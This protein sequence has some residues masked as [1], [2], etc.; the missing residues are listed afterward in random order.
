LGRYDLPTLP[1]DGHEPS[2][3]CACRVFEPIE[4]DGVTVGVRL[5]VDFGTSTTVAVL[6]GADGRVRPLLFDSSPLLAS[7]VFAGPGGDLLTGSD[8]ERAAVAHPAGL[9]ANPKRRISDGTVWLGEQEYAVVDLIAAV[10]A[11]VAGE[12]RR[13]AGEPPT[14]VVL[15]HP[16]SWS[17]V[18]LG[19]LADAAGRAGFEGVGFVAEPVAAAAYFATVLGRRIPQ[20]RC[21]VVYD[22]GAGTFDVSV[23]RPWAAGFEVVAAAGL[24]DVGGLDLDAAVVGHARSLTAG[25]GGVWARLDWPHTPADRQ[26]RYGLWRS[27]RAAKEQLSRHAAT[28]LHV[29]LVDTEVHLTREEF[30][31]AARPYLERTAALTLTVLRE[32]GTPQEEIGGVF[33]VGGSSRIPLAA[34]LLHR[35]LGITPTA[36]DHPELVVAEGSLHVGPVPG[37]RPSEPARG[38]VAAAQPAYAGRATSNQHRHPSHPPARHRPRPLPPHRRPS[39][40]TLTA[41]AAMVPHRPGKPRPAAGRAA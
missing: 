9:E 16:A 12:A 35:T 1:G 21:L 17:Q 27:A 28:D 4:G 15:T 32:A 34:T 10:L 39:T 41:P 7:A 22:L 25:S 2:C 5:G 20:D 24:D 33:L 40:S 26:A 36:L 23:V 19:V 8:A 29:P 3:R 18:R 13:V 14:A 38:D 37:P 6:A 30:E 11:R 31:K